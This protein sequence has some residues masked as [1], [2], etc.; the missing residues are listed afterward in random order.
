[1]RTTELSRTRDLDEFRRDYLDAGRAVVLEGGARPMPAFHLWSSRY[2][3]DKLKS[4]APTVRLPD[5]RLA[6]MGM[7]SFFG[8]FDAPERFASTQGPVYLTD[9]YLT[10]GFGEAAREIVARD[11]SCPFD[12]GEARAEWISLYAGPSGTGSPLHQDVFGTHTWLAQIRGTK[13]WRLC[14]PEAIDE[15][16]AFASDAFGE[17]ALPC[18]VYEAV[19]SP[20]D[21]IYLP[22]SWWHQVKNLTE[23]IA[24]SGNFCTFEH[25]RRALAEV[26]AR[27]ESSS[28]EVWRKTWRAVLE[29][30]P[31][32][33]R[34]AS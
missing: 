6:R 28:K 22:P 29:K 10:P 24:I 14:A 34:S 3:A 20:G 13:V 31:L 26:D 17:H 11:A 19:L 7:E 32:P 21:L 1:M 16:V 8:Y 30:A 27:P 2:L 25:A 5:G 33:L 12:R 9:F 4:C 18:T 15:A 23:T